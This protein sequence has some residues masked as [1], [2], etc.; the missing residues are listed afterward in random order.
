QGPPFF[1]VLLDAAVLVAKVHL[2]RRARPEDAG[3]EWLF[4]GDTPAVAAEHGVHLVWP[5]DADVVGDQ[6]FEE[7]TG[8]AGIVEHQRAGD[9]DLAHGQRPP[10]ARRPVR[11]GERW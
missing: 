9:L 8:P 10:V 7:A 1:E 11:G 2:H 4:A 3:R 5:A 6:R